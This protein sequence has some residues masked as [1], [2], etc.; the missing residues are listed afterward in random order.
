MD[1]N[2]GSICRLCPNGCDTCVN[3]TC[4]SC[5]ADYSASNSQCVKTCLLMGSCETT[6]AQVIPLPGVIFFAV[7]FGIVIA[8][9]LI[10]KKA[11]VPYSVMFLSCFIQFLLLLIT[12]GAA[13]NLPTSMRLLLGIDYSYRTN[14]KILLGLGVAFNYI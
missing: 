10:M 1:T 2:N 5:L 14:I 13:N 9:K 4:T 8:I 6:S 3:F 7:W 11:Y 12:L